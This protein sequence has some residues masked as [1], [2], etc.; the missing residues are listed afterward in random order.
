MF[1]EAAPLPG[2]TIDNDG[3]TADQTADRIMD[4]CARGEALV[5]SPDPT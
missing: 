4:A 3:L 2:F 1:A 5:W